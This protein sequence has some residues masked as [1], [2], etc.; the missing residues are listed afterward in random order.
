MYLFYST[1]IFKLP[2]T[3]PSSK[4]LRKSGEVVAGTAPLPFF[5]LV[6]TPPA[7]PGYLQMQ[8]YILLLQCGFLARRFFFTEVLHAV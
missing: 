6:R 1:L 4:N 2:P 8:Q 3:S 5:I 7:I